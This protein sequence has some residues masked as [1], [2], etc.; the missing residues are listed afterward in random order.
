VRELANIVERLAILHAGSVVGPQEIGTILAGS[1]APIATRHAYE[2]ADGS[3]P[4]G[5]RLD[6]YERTLLAE[7][8]DAADGSVAEAAR[9]LQTDRAN[10]YRR[11]R[12]LG[13]AR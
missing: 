9:R 5:E 6:A 13:I 7:A 12:R 8:L 11:M 4:L 2:E 1:A 10:L 3:L